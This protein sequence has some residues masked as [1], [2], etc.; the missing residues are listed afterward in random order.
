MRKTKSGKISVICLI[1]ARKGS[2]RLPGKNIKPLLGKPLIAYTIEQ[3]KSVSL[4]DRVIV[5]TDSREIAGI[6]RKFGAEVPF[7]RPRHLAR[8]LTPDWPV[9]KH[10]L[11]WLDVNQGYR[12]DFIV[13]LRCTGPLRK[14]SDIESGI[15]KMI[16]FRP[17]SVVSVS[18]VDHPPQKMWRISAGGNLVKLLSGRVR[19]KGGA[20]SPQQLLEPVYRQNDVVDVSRYDTIMKKKSMFG[21]RMLPLVTNRQ[22][23][24]DIDTPMDFLLAETI[25]K[26]RVK[27]PRLPKNG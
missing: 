9:F 5:S 20:E 25:M 26:K 17:D 1:P 24:L 12:P 19:L 6:A 10:A 22:D 15:R 21:R 16:K 3:A 14:V 7:I 13:H 18:P 11:K 8:N 2:R 23:S 4:I 27:A